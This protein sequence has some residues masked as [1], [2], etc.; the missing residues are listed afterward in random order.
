MMNAKTEETIKLENTL[1]NIAKG[2][3]KVELV[4]FGTIKDGYNDNVAEYFVVPTFYYEDFGFLYEKETEIFD[5]LEEVKK[6]LKSYEPIKSFDFC[7]KETDD[8]EDYDILE[9]VW[10]Y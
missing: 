10:N 5:L 4:S 9:I 8:E 2:Y 1:E 7:I 6:F 3:E